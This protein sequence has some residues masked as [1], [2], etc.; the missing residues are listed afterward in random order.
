MNTSEPRNPFYLLLLIASFLFAV[1]AI[2][3]AV[4]PTLEQ[5]ALE[6]GQ[7]APHSAWR[8]ALR[9]DGWQWLLW[10]LGAMALFAGLSMG[11][12]R[13]RSLKKE[14]SLGTILPAPNQPPGD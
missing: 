9:T 6:A 10:Q 12:D 14:R 3:Y 8:D 4:I 5:K 13:L 1:T 11:L 7:P 2:A